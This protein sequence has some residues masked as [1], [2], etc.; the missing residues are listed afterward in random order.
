M[1]WLNHT[2][3]SSSSLHSFYVSVTG[4]WAGT[5]YFPSFPASNPYVTAVGA[6]MGAGGAVPVGKPEVA[7]FRVFVSCSPPFLILISAF[8][9]DRWKVACQSNLGGE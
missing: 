7:C 3:C 2:Y 6:T 9:G 5:G 4:T 8:Y 1:I